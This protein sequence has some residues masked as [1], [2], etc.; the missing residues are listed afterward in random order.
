MHIRAA[1]L[2]LLSAAFLAPTQPASKVTPRVIEVSVVVKDKTGPVAGLDKDDFVLTDQGKAQRLVEFH[3]IKVPANAVGSAT[4]APAAPLSAHVYSNRLET[5]SP[6]PANTTVVLLDALN[7][8]VTDQVAVRKQFLTFLKQIRPTDRIAVY[9]LTTQL[10]V[11][12]EFTSDAA[13]LLA[14]VSKLTGGAS[15]SAPGDSALDR[16]VGE[17]SSSFAGFTVEIRAGITA[18]ALE[19][20]AHHVAQLPGRKSMVWISGTFPLAIGDMGSDSLN[21]IGTNINQAEF[22]RNLTRATRALSDADIAVYPTDPR[23]L[24]GLP[25]SQTAAGSTAVSHGAVITGATSDQSAIL[26]AHAVLRT[27]AENTGGE[28]YDNTNDFNG[29]IRK[30]IEDGQTSY[31]LA[32]SPDPS[33]LNGKFHSLKV[34]VK[35]PGVEVR[36]RRGYLATPIAAPSEKERGSEVR[37]AVASPLEA[38]GITLTAGVEADQPKAGTTRVI[39]AIDPKDLSFTEVGGKFAA[40]VDVVYSLRAADGK[41]LATTTQGLNINLPKEQYDAVM[42]DGMTVTKTFDAKPQVAEVRVAVYDRAT[43]RVGTLTLPPR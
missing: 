27:I 10:T 17:S 25:K 2:S 13:S 22:L 11:L 32:F 5:K 18:T 12:H 8:E 36:Y 15:A 26:S 1:A 19:A 38:M 42:K 34:Q 24:V 6:V 14:D 33:T 39:L 40:G 41:D 23:G 37:E 31:T 43:G 3:E 4:V 29:S 7:S 30:A 21:L 28:V 20:L 35:R 16:W 9:G